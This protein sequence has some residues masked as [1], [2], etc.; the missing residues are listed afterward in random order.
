MWDPY[1]KRDIDL[2]ESAQ[3]FGLRVCLK[4]WSSPYENL[5]QESKIQTLSERR[6]QTNLA[7]LHKIV[8]EKIDF[9]GAPINRTFH[10]S[11]RAN[12]S[13]SLILF[14]CKTSQFLY[15]YFPKTVKGWNSLPEDIVTLQST[16]TF[17]CLLSSNI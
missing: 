5:L 15:S 4:D 14:S 2:L 12:N 8:H 16:H 3:K 9:P 11:S 6:T 7:Y 1:L 17:K 13:H 10:Y